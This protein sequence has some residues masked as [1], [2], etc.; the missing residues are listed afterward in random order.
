MKTGTKG[1][2]LAAIFAL[3]GIVM[4]AGC[5][6]SSDSGDN[7]AAGQAIY[8]ANC[9]TCHGATAAGGGI[10][11]NIQG[12]TAAQISTALATVPQ[13]SGISLDSASITA[14]AEYLATL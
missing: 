5:G 8:A 4:L 10:Y 11:P 2:L 13:M 9:A 6:S 12:K 7:V 3:M 14:V 1:L